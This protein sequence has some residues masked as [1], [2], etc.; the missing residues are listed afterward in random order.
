MRKQTSRYSRSIHDHDIPLTALSLVSLALTLVADRLGRRRILLLGAL[1]MTLSGTVFATISNYW[2]LL[3]AA[4]VGVISPSGNEIGPF[5]AVEESTLAHLSEEK[6]RSDIF[7]LYVVVGTL[8]TAGGSL[9][10]GWTTQAVH[11]RGWSDI[12]SYGLIFWVYAMIGLVK[13]GLTLLLSGKCEV[14]AQPASQTVELQS[15]T[16]ERNEEQQP[17]LGETG[18]E[19][20]EPP[21]QPKKREKK[22]SWIQLSAKSRYTLLRLC[23]LFF[24]DSL[25]R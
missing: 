19:D 20:E 1:L 11:G 5:R 10:A 3:L 6:T 13:A 2:I 4:I 7:A 17:F 22:T 21:Q 23:G 16:R 25:A 8:G 14:Q 9:A 24:F 12:A 15:N 18:E